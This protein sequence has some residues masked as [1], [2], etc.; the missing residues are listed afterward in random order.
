MQKFSPVAQELADLQSNSLLAKMLILVPG[1]Q[2]LWLVA[3]Y[4]FSDFEIE[5]IN[6]SYHYFK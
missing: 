3:S 4:R 1:F 2:P 6:L 5:S